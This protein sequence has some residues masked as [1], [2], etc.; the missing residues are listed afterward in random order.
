ML[1]SSWFCCGRCQRLLGSGGSPGG[2]RAGECREGVRVSRSRG[3]GSL[4]TACSCGS[5][6][7]P[8]MAPTPEKPRALDCNVSLV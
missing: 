8:E 6:S 3:A 7:S 5:W 4:T 2:R 1:F